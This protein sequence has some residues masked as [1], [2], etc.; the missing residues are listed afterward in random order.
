[1][2]KFM[3]FLTIIG[4]LLYF[5]TYQKVKVSSDITNFNFLHT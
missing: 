4:H 3:A 2:N 5:C 1:M